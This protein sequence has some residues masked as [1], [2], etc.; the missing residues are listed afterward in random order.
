MRLIHD[1]PPRP[2]SARRFAVA[3]EPGQPE[4]IAATWSRDIAAALGDAPHTPVT[5]LARHLT[6]R[7]RVPA[8]WLLHTGLHTAGHQVNITVV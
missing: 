1:P 5:G 7:E 4:S 2:A 8:P 6:L 3:T